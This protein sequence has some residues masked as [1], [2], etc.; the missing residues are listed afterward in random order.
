LRSGSAHC[1]LELAIE[2][3]EEEEGG[4]KEEEVTLIKSGDP[5]LVRVIRWGTTN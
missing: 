1:C 4:R 3:L 2:E 5:H